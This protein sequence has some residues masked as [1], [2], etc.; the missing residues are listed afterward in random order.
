MQIQ[1]FHIC[2]SM[3]RHYGRK[4]R[5]NLWSPD[6]RIAHCGRAIEK[7][8]NVAA[9]H[10]VSTYNIPITTPDTSNAFSLNFQ[11]EPTE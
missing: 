7:V 11:N 6:G 9:I 10:G 8:N 4:Y 3:M 5:L 1:L 2:K